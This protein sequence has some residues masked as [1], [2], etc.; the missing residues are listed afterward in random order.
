MIMN[1]RW[2]IFDFPTNRLTNKDT[3]LMAAAFKLWLDNDCQTG[4]SPT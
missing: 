1:F 2:S 4:L 3:K